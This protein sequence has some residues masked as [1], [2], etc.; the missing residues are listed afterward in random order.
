MAED[1][2]QWCQIDSVIP[3]Q[4]LCR[5]CHQKI[6]SDI[7]LK[8]DEDFAKNNLED[9]SPDFNTGSQNSSEGFVS[10][11][12]VKNRIDDVCKTLDL[13]PLKLKEYHDSDK[14]KIAKRNWSSSLQL[15]KPALKSVSNLAK[16]LIYKKI[17]VSAR[18]MNFL[19]KCYL[20]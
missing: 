7:Q 17:S 18:T 1:I 4:K 13:S 8:K 19:K 10:S 11:Q 9:E 16:M 12:Q 6:L 2:G 3:G 20:N 14:K 5:Y 15:Q